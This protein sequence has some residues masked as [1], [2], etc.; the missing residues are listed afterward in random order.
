[1]KQHL[2]ETEASKNIFEIASPLHVSL[3]S[4]IDLFKPYSISFCIQY[5]LTLELKIGLGSFQRL[6][7]FK[8]GRLAK[9]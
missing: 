3:V 7:Y 8:L 5:N 4:K 6:I 9:K 2:T 1:M